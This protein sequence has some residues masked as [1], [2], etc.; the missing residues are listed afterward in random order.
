MTLS[1]V[2]RDVYLNHVTSS[3]T[4]LEVYIGV[5][6]QTFWLDGPKYETT[7]TLP[8]GYDRTLTFSLKLD[9]VPIPHSPKSIDFFPV[10]DG[11]WSTSD[12]LKVVIAGGFTFTVVLLVTINM[13]NMKGT[14]TV[15]KG[16]VSAEC[17]KNNKNVTAEGFDIS[18]DYMNFLIV[19]R[20]CQAMASPYLVF[21][22]TATV[23]SGWSIFI[24]LKQNYDLVQNGMPVIEDELLD[25]ALKFA[26][27]HPALAA[28]GK[29]GEEGDI[30]APNVMNHLQKLKTAFFSRAAKI[31]P[32]VSGT[33]DCAPIWFQTYKHRRD[34]E[35][36]LAAS[37]RWKERMKA[38]FLV[39]FL[40]DI[41]FLLM[42]LD[43]I[44]G[45]EVVGCKDTEIVAIFVVATFASA[46]LLGTKIQKLLG[47]VG[48]NGIAQKIKDL[49][50]EVRALTMK[51]LAEFVI[52]SEGRGDREVFVYVDENGDDAVE[53]GGRRT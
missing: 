22:G 3:S 7:F 23:A 28:E 15:S 50:R 8:K 31:L 29:A 25:H 27:E 16:T 12:I 39:V 34:A 20:G 38:M 13:Q 18:T 24:N 10:V 49:E 14:S 40:E 19:A 42:N 37:M 17:A 43:L 44:A 5:L 21:L 2:V 33:E 41:P 4:K 45:T 36:K 47:I 35:L 46:I 53:G 26:K 30:E 1:A 9:G 32:F 52:H 51:G 6:N 11:S 48:S